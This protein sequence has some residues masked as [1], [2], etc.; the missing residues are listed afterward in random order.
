MLLKISQKLRPGALLALV[1]IAVLALAACD[2][3]DTAPQPEVAPV[4]ADTPTPLPDMSA[5]E[6]MTGTDMIT[7]TEGMT[8]TEGMTGTNGVTNTQGTGAQGA[9]VAA[10][11]TGVSGAEGMFIRATTLTDYDFINQDGQISGNVDDFLVDVATGNILFAFVEYGGILDIGDTNLVMPLDAFQ[12]GDGQLILNFDEQELQNFPGVGD[13]WPDINDPAWD[14]DVTTFWRSIN[15]DPGFDFNE[16]NSANVMWLSDMTGYVLADLG[17]GTGT[18]QDV[19]VDLAHSRIKYV[20]FG[21]G[22]TAANTDPYII[23]YSALD[24]QTIANNEIAFNSSIDLA[25]LQTAPRY[26]RN[27]YPNV[28]VLT[29]DFSTEIDQYWAD[30]GFNVN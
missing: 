3:D 7:T 20:L 19:L 4:V 13:N 18:I 28:Q 29:S 6:A 21:F 11:M 5:T 2:A 1:L 23:P 30:Q 9:D 10:G 27:L 24:V 8:A 22:T 25:T 14:D 15:L 16:T 17:E 12:M 26:D